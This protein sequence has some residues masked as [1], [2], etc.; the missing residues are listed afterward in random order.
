MRFGGVPKI[1]SPIK[2]AGPQVFRGHGVRQPDA[3][4][5]SKERDPVPPHPTGF[6]DQDYRLPSTLTDLASRFQIGGQVDVLTASPYQPRRLDRIQELGDSPVVQQLGRLNR[7]EPQIDLDGMPLVGPNS[8]TIWTDGEPLLV[9]L[10]DNT[11]Q[12]WAGQLL[13]ST[14]R[15]GQQ[16]V[17]RDPALVIQGDV[18]RLR[19]VSQHQAQEFA[20][21][22]QFA[23]HLRT[24]NKNGQTALKV[25]AERPSHGFH[26]DSIGRLDKSSC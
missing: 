17:D 6:D 19:L 21:G 22:D 15:G 16:H 1:D 7:L 8:L 2:S 26:G 11:F 13:A 12:Q 23:V 18:D 9:V 4:F 25:F 5:G 20:G 24:V 3:V 14:I 10:A